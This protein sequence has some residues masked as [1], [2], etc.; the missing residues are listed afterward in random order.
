LISNEQNYAGKPIKLLDILTI[1]ASKM[2][3]FKKL[4]SNEKI[5]TVKPIKFL[6]ILAIKKKHVFKFDIK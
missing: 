5:Y 1:V 6:N 4:I 3:C 2:S